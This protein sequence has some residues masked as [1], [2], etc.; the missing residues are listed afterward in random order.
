[1]LFHLTARE[2]RAMAIIATLIVLGL[3]GLWVL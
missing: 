1:M 2:R 3:I